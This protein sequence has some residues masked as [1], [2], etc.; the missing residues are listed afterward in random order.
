MGRE[1]VS[2]LRAPTSDLARNLVQARGAEP[3]DPR[4]FFPIPF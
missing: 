1:L 2:G 4:L 3:F